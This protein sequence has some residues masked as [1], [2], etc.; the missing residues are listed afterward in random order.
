M[1]GDSQ[2]FAEVIAKAQRVTAGDTANP[3]NLPEKNVMLPGKIPGVEKYDYKS[4]AVVFCLPADS[5]AY[6]EVMDQILAGEAIL[7]YEDRSWDKEGNFNVAMVYL[8]PRDKRASVDDGEAAG[9][10]EPKLRPMKLP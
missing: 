4:Q 2:D 9:E 5:T 6:E 8:I 7:R 3:F 1:K 10:E